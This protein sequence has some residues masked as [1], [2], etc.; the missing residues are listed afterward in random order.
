MS[1]ISSVVLVLG[2]AI[3]SVA[4]FT[5]IGKTFQVQVGANGNLTFDPETIVANVGDTVVYNFH[6]KVSLP[7]WNILETTVNNFNRIILLLSRVSKIHATL[8]REVSS[9][10]LCPQTTPPQHLPQLLPSLLMIPSQSGSTVPK[11][12]RAIA[13]MEWCM[14][15]MRSLI[16]K[17]IS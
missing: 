5:S 15:L 9:L 14:Q 16:S 12:K 4:G 8:S 17:L 13:R 1:F 2:V 7:V 3:S 11:L 10:G 6:P